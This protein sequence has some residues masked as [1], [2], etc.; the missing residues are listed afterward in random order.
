MSV[1]LFYVCSSCS[2]VVFCSRL[3][4]PLYGRPAG[5]LT[6]GQMDSYKDRVERSFSTGTILTV[7]CLVFGKATECGSVMLSVSN[8]HKG[9]TTEN[10]WCVVWLEVND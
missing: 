6:D 3:R 2:V 9:S 1:C 5:Q 7:A 10:G 8:P 4:L